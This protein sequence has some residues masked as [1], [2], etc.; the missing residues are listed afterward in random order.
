M[1]RLSI[2]MMKNTCLGSKYN[3]NVHV[4]YNVRFL[5]YSV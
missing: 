1:L 2:L 3:N 4:T 5:N